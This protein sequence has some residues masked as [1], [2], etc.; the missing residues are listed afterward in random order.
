MYNRRKRKVFLEEQHVLLQERL[1]EARTAAARGAAD[2]DQILLLNR[3]RAAE[4]ADE[5]K[6]SRKTLWKSIKGVFSTEGLQEEDTHGKL[7]TETEDS[8]GLPETGSFE[9][10]EQKQVPEEYP[11]NGT[12]LHAM[13]ERRREGE[14]ELERR[15]AEGGVLDKLAEQAASTEPGKRDWT[16]WLSWR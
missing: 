5:A 10:P 12:I 4:E 3:E 13:E 9:I 15:G 8:R 16:S 7:N 6:K 2:E 1:V 14:R 11:K